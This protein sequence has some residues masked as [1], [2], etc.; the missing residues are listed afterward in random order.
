M[1]LRDQKAF[2]S[3]NE[4]LELPVNLQ[5]RVTDSREDFILSSNISGKIQ[6]PLG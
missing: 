4:L 2:P 3:I 6:L 5:R 1:M